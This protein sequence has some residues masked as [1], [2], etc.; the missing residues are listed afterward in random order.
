LWTFAK[1]RSALMD[2]F[3]KDEVAAADLQIVP[4]EGKGL[5]ISLSRDS[6]TLASLGWKNLD[7]FQVGLPDPSKHTVHLSP[8]LQRV[9]GSPGVCMEISVYP[10]QACR[11]IK[12]HVL[13]QA[14]VQDLCL[15]M[16]GD[17]VELHDDLVAKSI[18]RGCDLELKLSPRLQWLEAKASIR[19][20]TVM[21]VR[22]STPK[23]A[24]G[25]RLI[26]S[27]PPR[28]MMIGIKPLGAISA[29]AVAVADHE[30]LPDVI[31][32]R[33]FSPLPH[34][35]RYTQYRL[36]EIPKASCY[37][38]ALESYVLASLESHRASLGSTDRAPPPEIV[39]TS[40][41]S[42]FNPRLLEKFT[43][44][45]QHMSG[46][47]RKACP[48][49]KM[50]TGMALDPT[51]GESLNEVL[52]YHGAKDEDIDQICAAGFDPRRGGQSAGRLFG[53]G[54]YFAENF[55]KADLYAGPQPFVCHRGPMSVLV[56]RVALGNAY[57]TKQAMREIAMPPERPRTR[58]PH[59]SVVAL[60]RDEGGCV[61]HREYVVY[62]DAQTLPVFRINYCHADEC[63]CARCSVPAP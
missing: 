16:R 31:I 47:N 58:N 53:R 24:P 9:S 21:L 5:P 23:Y 45:L 15:M 20:G 14:D 42:V 35:N 34:C 30:E 29:K 33:L 6:L 25:H 44:E 51:F 22:T 7:K 3:R 49:V 61:D 36:S 41:Q 56:A 17:T 46:L 32:R 63:E 52:L 55:S 19:D 4:D 62:K 27:G 12:S 18:R 60:R 11:W 54:T 2:C 48:P 39:F 40:I 13:P 38:V 50:T 28:G 1:V 37:F 43:L 59:D 10:G 26:A 57:S 8:T